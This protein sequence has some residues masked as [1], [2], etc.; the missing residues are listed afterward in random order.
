MIPKELIMPGNRA[1]KAQ[2]RR[3][4]NDRIKNHQTALENR[5]LA[6]RR[7]F[8]G[9]GIGRVPVR[10]PGGENPRGW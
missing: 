7:H 8:H 9:F 6:L 4:S 10:Q 1:E 2:Q 5:H 3:Q